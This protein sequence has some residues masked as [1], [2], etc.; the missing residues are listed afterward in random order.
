M[1]TKQ[2][3]IRQVLDK[4]FIFNVLP[5]KTKQAIEPMFEVE[6]FA[7]G[8][9]IATPGAVMPGFYAIY[10]GTVRFKA[11]EGGRRVSIGVQ[12]Q[13]GTFGEISLLQEARWDHEIV[14]DT[15]T[16]LLTLQA[17]KF[18]ELLAQDPQ[19]E[20][21][22]K[23][24]IGTIELHRRLRGI[25]G[26]TNYDPGLAE[27]LIGDIGVKKIRRGAPVFKQ[28]QEDP[29]LYYVETGSV[30]LVRD[31]VEGT[32]VLDKASA[33][34]LVGEEGALRQTPHSYTAMAVTDVTVLVIRQ[35][36]VQ[37]I[38]EA[39]YELKE[40]LEARIE[41]LRQDEEESAEAVKRAEGV[42][43]RI[44]IE[45]ITE[46]E[47]KRLEKKKEVE[48]FPIVRQQDEIECPAACLSMVT[49]H[50]GKRFTIGQ[51]RELANIAEAEA[52]VHQV[53]RAAESLGFRAK[54]Y[55]C[56][57]E[58][59]SK[60]ELP[61]IVWWENYHYAVLYRV[62]RK[63]A[64]LADPA[65][66]NRKL[67]REDFEEG[68]TGVVIT[69]EPTQRFL[70]REPP[71]NP[72]MHFISY[73]LPYW[74]HFGEA[75]VAALI[76]NFLGLATPLFVQN[77]V[78]SVVPH[79]NASLLNIM[80]VG[81]ALVTLFRLATGAAQSLL[82]AHTV[83]RID[84]KLVSEF[85]M[86]ILSLPMTFFTSRRTGDI[87]ARFG[88][89][90][91][92]RRLIAGST[93]TVI[94]NTLMVVVYLLMMW[95][96][97]GTLTLIV[98]GFV[99]LYILNTLYFTPKLK[100][101]ANEIFLTNARQQSHLIESLHGIEAI[102]ATA[103]EYYARA[104]WEDSFVQNVNQH[105][106]SA[107]LSLLSGSIGQLLN[108]SS[109]LIILYIGANMVMSPE[110]P[111][112]IGQLM[113]F[114]MLMGA[115]MGPIMAMVALWDSAQEV[116]ISVERVSDVNNVMP[117]QPP[118][119]SPEELPAVLPDLEGKVEIREV[120]F[121]YGGEETPLVLNKLSLT[122]EPGQTVALVG[123]S[124]C[125]K[126]TVIRLLMGFIVPN[127]GEVLIDGKE[128]RKLDFAS[129]RRQ[130]GVVLQDS[131]LFSD[132]VAANIALGDPEPDINLVRR[133]AR[134]SSADDFIARL[135]TG[136]QTMIGE[137]GVQVSG[138]QRQRLC[139]A[140]ALYH[141]PKILIFDEA[142]SALDNE[143]EER[144]QQNMRSIL[145]GRTAIVI[146]HRL[147]TIQDAD[148]IC[149]LENGHVME[150]GSHDELIEKRGR[151]FEMAKKQFGLE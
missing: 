15:E 58:T 31:M 11:L 7:P 137:K 101:V 95:A 105:Y 89:N 84:M 4:H 8:D 44:K 139:I 121:R 75:F 151:Y 13:G 128:I 83:A 65:K 66:G 87:L 116:R 29:R 49:R 82:L 35:E 70:R 148:F 40:R 118:A 59:L 140:R 108:L 72:Y 30:E 97:S 28:G 142:T 60:L 147:S 119:D 100:R 114:N 136:Y 120:D 106:H 94:L 138:G 90:Q 5:E 54:P 55:R 38:L 131:F 47:F 52:T 91:K 130:I 109:S 129:Y 24:Q 50:Y 123:P 146:A 57:W 6:T 143:S 64:F 46:S 81:M 110:V 62:T 33:G 111:F 134:L 18:R 61:C 21:H 69:L 150:Q 37:K 124:G 39:N 122:I 98:V 125:G 133:A 112:T 1:P 107:K 104:R 127:A 68:W 41:Q 56:D 132:T 113:G 19:L 20:S 80:L 10:S 48:S 71:P 74:H 53:C 9:V 102:K 22:V 17:Q 25:L 144:I 63:H 103:N 88:E 86:H 77:I 135:P 36:G 43:Q 115:V 99:P 32:V 126:S 3:A 141:Q 51:I 67:A 76:I 16:T 12:K 117:E 42:D 23:Q 27:E 26:S 145:A 79:N 92:I 73:L 85:Y 34:D 96:Y 93:I 149:F 2:E 78:D 14:A 45:A